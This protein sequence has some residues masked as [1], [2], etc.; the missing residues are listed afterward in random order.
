MPSAS[1]RSLCLACCILCCLCLA[2]AILIICDRWMRGF[3]F[4]LLGLLWRWA[5]ITTNNW[6]STLCSLLFSHGFG[7]QTLPLVLGHVSLAVC[8]HRKPH[9]ICEAAH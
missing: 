2:A 7:N 9:I 3:F 6:A 4:L 5:I 1:G 8:Q